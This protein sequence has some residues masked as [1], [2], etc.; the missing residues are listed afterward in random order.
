MIRRITIIGLAFGLLPAAIAMADV[1]G[2]ETVIIE[3]QTAVIMESAV[4]APPPAWVEFESTAIAAG[5]G[6]RVGSGT[7][8]VAG[9]EHPFTIKGISLGDFG[10]S[11]VSADG[12]VAGLENVSD[13]EGRYL[14]VE[15]GAA[16]GLGASV[17]TM[18][19]DKGVS[20]TLRGDVKGL[21][22]KLGAEGIEIKLQ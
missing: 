15:A 22:L 7:L 2:G 1:T 17:L 4:S 10:L 21:Q 19:N 20:M 16:A 14:A 6:A 12:E 9:E 13:F 18:R 3:E 5:I 8:L 11:R